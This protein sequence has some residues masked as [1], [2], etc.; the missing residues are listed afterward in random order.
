VREPT[1]AVIIM[2][3]ASLDGTVVTVTGQGGAEH[4]S[5]NAANNYRAA[6]LVE[7]GRYWV[8][9]EREGAVLLRR[10]VE[11]ERFLAVQF[12]L[13]RLDQERPPDPSRNAGAGAEAGAGAAKP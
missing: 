6:V 1:T 8:K 3:D 10:E 5:L 13:S 7:P 12:D 9:A 2:G 4:T 11:V